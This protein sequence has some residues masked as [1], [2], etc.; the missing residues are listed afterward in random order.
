VRAVGCASNLRAVLPKPKSV[1]PAARREVETMARCDPL[2]RELFADA[3]R[4]VGYVESRAPG[5]RLALLD[6]GG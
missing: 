6:V 5:E 2:T 4:T 1:A 3:D